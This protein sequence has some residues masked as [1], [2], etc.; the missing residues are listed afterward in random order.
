MQP[1]LR[2][3]CIRE[4]QRSLEQSD[5]RLVEDKIEA[6]GVSNSVRVLQT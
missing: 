3:V 5:K 1:G 2:W 6:L 4:V